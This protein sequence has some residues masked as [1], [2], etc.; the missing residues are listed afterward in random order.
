MLL[1]QAIILA[2]TISFAFDTPSGVPEGVIFL[3]PERRHKGSEI[4]S[5]AGIGTLVLEWTRL[6]DLT[7]N[8]TYAQLV[9][10]SESYLV[11]P[12]GVPEAFPGLVGWN[13]RL[14]TGEFVDNEGGWGAGTDSFYEYL[15]KM[16]LYD[17]E[18]FAGYKD[19]WVLAADST[20]EHLASHPTS[21]EDLTFLLQ[22]QGKNLRPSSGHRK[23]IALP[24][25]S[26]FP[27]RPR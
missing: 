3:N 8:D 21:R 7:G 17:P 10:K 9:K 11:D 1:L 15:I 26:P 24:S 6:S 20:M 4:N 19:R 2:D 5:I 23:L 12:T 25:F 13:V 22:F 16:Y 18:E 14:E 27:H